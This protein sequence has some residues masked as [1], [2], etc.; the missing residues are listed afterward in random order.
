VGENTDIVRRLF[1]AFSRRDLGAVTGLCA[2]DV[3]FVP[4]TLTLLARDE[5]YRGPEGMRE[6]FEDVA[7][8]WQEL[9]V[10]P[11]TYYEIGDRVVALGRVYAWGVGRVID[12]PVG[13][14]WRVGG[15]RVVHGQV[16]DTRRAALETAGIREGEEPPP[17]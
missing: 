2:P 15:G 4:M 1:E 14:V 5:P 12:A 9:R 17:V 16:F 11:D 3:E 7:R 10:E 8:M 13:W 6:Y